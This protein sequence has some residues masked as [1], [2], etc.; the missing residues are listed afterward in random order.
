MWKDILKAEAVVAG[1]RNDWLDIGEKVA[2]EIKYGGNEKACYINLDD[3]GFKLNADDSGDD[4]AISV[5]AYGEIVVV[6]NDIGEDIKTLTPKDINFSVEIDAKSVKADNDTI[7]LGAEYY[8]ENFYKGK[9]DI[10]VV[11]G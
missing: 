1:N 3:F 9:L 7:V 4:L 5:E 10:S 11:L 2:K 6:D 8:L